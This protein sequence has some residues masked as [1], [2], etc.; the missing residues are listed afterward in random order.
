MCGFKLV[1]SATAFFLFCCLCPRQFTPSKMLNLTAHKSRGNSEF[2]PFKFCFYLLRAKIFSGQANDCR[3]NTVEG[4]E[5]AWTTLLIQSTDC[6][7]NVT[8]R[9]LP[10]TSLLSEVQ[11]LLCSVGPLQWRVV[12]L[13]HPAGQRHCAPHGH[14]LI[15]GHRLQRV[16]F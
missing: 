6:I 8:P 11:G 9:P 1:S 7:P 16:L 13:G 15:S 12:R 2:L 5:A 14:R 3:L 4:D 10:P